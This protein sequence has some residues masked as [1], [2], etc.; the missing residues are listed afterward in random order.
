VF[1]KICGITNADDARAAVDHGASALGFVLWP[2]SPRFI[3][4]EQARDIVV[5]LPP[6]VIAVG[7]FVDHP[8]LLVNELAAEIGLGA[9]QLHGNEGPEVAASITRPVFKAVT[10]GGGRPVL[11]EWPQRV[12]LLVDAHDPVRRGGT[13]MKAD[14]TAAA[15]LARKRRV[16]LAGGLTPENVGD[17]IAQ[18]KPFGIDVS[19]GVEKSPGVKDHSRL[20]ALFAA[21]RSQAQ[22][23]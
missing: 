20:A 3:E 13:G 10:I 21:L 15:S 14:W 4:P 22:A 12:T 8:A 17:A 1:V 19:S 23:L 6:T 5:T 18:V 9:V 2:A 7:V 16:I 11:A